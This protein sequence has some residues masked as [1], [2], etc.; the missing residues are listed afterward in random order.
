[1]RI[2]TKVI[3]TQTQTPTNTTVAQI[4]TRHP[5]AVQAQTPIDTVIQMLAKYRISGLP[6]INDR[7]EVIGVVSEADLLWRESGV[8]PP[9]YLV[10]F[11]SVIYLTNPIAHD[12]DLHKVLAQTVGEVMSHHPVTITENQTLAEAAR[13]LHDRHV[14]RLPVLNPQGQLVGILTQGDI[15]RA[16]AKALNPV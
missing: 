10:I 2:P 1:M 12:R 14:H 7:Q 9:P 8:V 13:I 16:M 5:K 6:V 15:I 11:D 4:M 3:P